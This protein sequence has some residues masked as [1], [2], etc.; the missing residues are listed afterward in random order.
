M[1]NWI[2][3]ALAA[4]A[5]TLLILCF[6][7]PG[8]ET[9]ASAAP[10]G[11]LQLRV[12]DGAT[13]EPLAGATVVI[14]ETGAASVT[15]E[16]GLTEKFAVPIEPPAAY[17]AFAPASWGEVT[18]LVYKEGYADYALFHVEVWENQL[19]SGPNVYLFAQSPSDYQQPF[20]IVEG[21]PR[22]WVNGLLD[23]FRP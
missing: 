7:L 22:L 6:S 20:S 23:Q 2:F 5:L 11:F 21:P 13:E 18:V 17:Q 1:K 8:E 15:D 19:R 10:S 9:P 12:L 16:N 4:L 14:P 3:P